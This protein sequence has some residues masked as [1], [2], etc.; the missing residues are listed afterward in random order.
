MLSQL[1][2]QLKRNPNDSASQMLSHAHLEGGPILTGNLTWK[3]QRSTITTRFA[4]DLFRTTSYYFRRLA[5]GLVSCARFC[6]WRRRVGKNE[7]LQTRP[8]GLLP[9]ASETADGIRVGRGERVLSSMR[10]ERDVTPERRFSG[11]GV[12][13]PGACLRKLLTCFSSGSASFA[14]DFLPR[15][16]I[17]TAASFAGSLTVSFL[18]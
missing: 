7:L 3:L 6:S 1:S 15:L 11:R 16:S 4:L 17:S 2:A 10:H 12:G 5:A 14:F 18:Y 9:E 13:S 8:G